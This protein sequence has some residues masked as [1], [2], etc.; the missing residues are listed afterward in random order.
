MDIAL[1]KIHQLCCRVVFLI[2]IDIFSVRTIW[3]WSRHSGGTEVVPLTR[4]HRLNHF[5]P[6]RR[7]SLL[8]LHLQFIRTSN[9]DL[10]LNATSA[11]QSDFVL[12]C[13][14]LSDEAFE[15]SVVSIEEVKQYGVFEILGFGM[16]CCVPCVWLHCRF[17]LSTGSKGRSANTWEWL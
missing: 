17:L 4:Y 7:R 13:V 10:I 15:K 14:H 3:L 1:L 12:S 16:G 2:D 9:I 5:L 6:V 11:L 8:E